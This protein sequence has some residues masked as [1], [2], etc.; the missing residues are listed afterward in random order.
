M[1]EPLSEPL[2]SVPP[3]V[4]P[5]AAGSLAVDQEPPSSV[6]DVAREL[7]TLLAGMTG[8]VD[9]LSGSLA[10]ELADR[11]DLDY[12]LVDAAHDV[13]QIAEAA[14]RATVLAELLLQ[15]SEPCGARDGSAGPALRVAS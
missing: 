2:P 9:L 1:S 6:E 7:A 5:D 13:A 15:T 11:G 3:P 12:V 4:R 10:R 8:Y 14:D